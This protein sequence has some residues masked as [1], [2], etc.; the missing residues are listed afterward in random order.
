MK[1]RLALQGGFLT[2]IQKSR[3]SVFS[4]LIRRVI[5]DKQNYN[6]KEKWKRPRFSDTMQLLNA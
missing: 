3:F 4:S 5:F 1:S 2:F 6:A